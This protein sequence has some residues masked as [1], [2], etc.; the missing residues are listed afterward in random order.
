KTFLVIVPIMVFGVVFGFLGHYVQVG[1]LFTAEPVKA[2][3]ER[4]DPI[5]GIKRRF[6][7]RALVE[8]PKSLLKIAIL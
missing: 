7:V 3:L 2:K 1:P 6:S 5:K 8:L 4:L